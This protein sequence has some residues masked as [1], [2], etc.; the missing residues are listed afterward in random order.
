M[1]DDEDDSDAVKMRVKSQ[2]LAKVK[3]DNGF[4]VPWNCFKSTRWVSLHMNV[5]I[6]LANFLHLLNYNSQLFNLVSSLFDY[7]SHTKF[8]SFFSCIHILHF[9]L[10]IKL[11]LVYLRWLVFKGFFH[12]LFKSNLISIEVTI[13]FI[14]QKNLKWIKRKITKANQR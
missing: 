3:G 11:L 2:G 1:E 6:F 9:A 10:L 12:L 4:L 5:N 7:F 13:G 14:F 8:I